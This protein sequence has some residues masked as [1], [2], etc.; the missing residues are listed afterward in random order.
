MENFG[1]GGTSSRGIEMSSMTR[2]EIF[3]PDAVMTTVAMS[4]NPSAPV[5][6]SD[7]GTGALPATVMLWELMSDGGPPTVPAL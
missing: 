3:P 6:V 4:P 5:W 2:S 7:T 1:G